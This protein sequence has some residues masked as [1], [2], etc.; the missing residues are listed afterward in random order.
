[1]KQN[2]NK[3]EFKII[4]NEKKIYCTQCGEELDEFSLNEDCKNLDEVKKRWDNCKSTGK[5][6]GDICSK[7]FI[8]DKS[9]DNQSIFDDEEEID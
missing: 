8:A 6:K 9:M 4:N 7:V 1:M 2:K 5:F 3:V